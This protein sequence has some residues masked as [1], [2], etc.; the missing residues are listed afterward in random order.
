MHGQIHLDKLDN[1]L[2]DR[3]LTHSTFVVTAS[4]RPVQE[5]YI[6]GPDA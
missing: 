1:A 2:A 4:H 5:R 6:S 3:H